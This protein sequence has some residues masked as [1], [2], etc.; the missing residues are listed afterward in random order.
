MKQHLILHVVAKIMIP[1]FMLY[2]LYVQFHG[3]YSPGGGFQAGVIFGAGFILYGIVLGRAAAMKIVPPRLVHLTAAWGVLLY[4][5]V[6]VIGIFRGGEFLNY[7]VLL[8]SAIAGQ[9]LGII[10][11]ELGVGITVASVM[12]ALFLSFANYQQPN[13]PLSD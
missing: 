2:A 5:G 4:T 9:H 12:I 7:S 1:F 3:E 13:L 6:G 11:I 8:P 10:L